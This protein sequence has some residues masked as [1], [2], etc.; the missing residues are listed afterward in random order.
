[1]YGVTTRQECADSWIATFQWI[2]AESI[3]HCSRGTRGTHPKPISLLNSNGGLIS[4]IIDCSQVRT[5]GPVVYRPS[6]KK[7]D[8]RQHRRTCYLHPLSHLIFSDLLFSHSLRSSPSNFLRFSE[9]LPLLDDSPCRSSSTLPFDPILVPI[10]ASGASPL[11]SVRV[12][13][14]PAV[15]W[16]AVGLPGRINLLATM[17]TCYWAPAQCIIPVSLRQ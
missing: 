6:Q 12:S 2:T 9:H 7:R 17:T 10:N 16:P 4:L 15:A 13:A 11:R 14:S 5:S 8:D 3:E 1:M